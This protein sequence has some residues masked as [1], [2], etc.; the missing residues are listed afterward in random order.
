MTALRL[1]AA[2]YRLAGRRLSALLL[3]PIAAYFFVT[4]PRA[5]R[6]SLQYLRTLHAWSNGTALARP[7]R[8]IDAFRHFHVFAVSA[9]D[10]MVAW[11]GGF[12]RF[13]FTHTGSEHLFRLAREGRG[14]ILLGAHLGSYDMPRLLASEYGLILNVVMFTAHAERV[15]A[16][17]ERL[18]PGSRV[19]V[20]QLDPNS[21]HSALAVRAC[22]ARGEL[23]AFLADRPPP[24]A[25]G[26]R[27]VD[28]DFLGRAARLPL[29]PFL[30]ACTL[31]TPVLTSICV[32]TGDGTY[33]A[34]VELLSPGEVVPRRERAVRAAA[35]AH[36]YA[37]VLEQTCVRYPYQWFNFYD[38]W[39]G[40]EEKGREP[41]SGRPLGGRGSCGAARSTIDSDSLTD[42]E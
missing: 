32:R 8:P 20:L 29:S 22:L 28:V 41:L 23:V 40:T 17:F 27:T 34:A 24:G 14:G 6:A 12:D 38:Y 21:V 7:P 33:A 10:R 4:V 36:Q 11:G 26:A 37:R 25:A 35:L 2:I 5:R 15:N 9:F 18:D 19:R 1:M 13:A 3:Y 30:V 31:G 39:A 42:S 16:F